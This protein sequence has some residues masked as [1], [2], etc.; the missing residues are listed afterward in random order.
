MPEQ[1]E[2]EDQWESLELYLYQEP[3][4]DGCTCNLLEEWPEYPHS[5]HHETGKKE[6]GALKDVKAY[7]RNPEQFNWNYFLCLW[8]LEERCEYEQDLYGT[9]TTKQSEIKGERRYFRCSYKRILKRLAKGRY[10]L[11]EWYA[12]RWGDFDIPKVYNLQIFRRYVNIIYDLT[13]LKVNQKRDLPQK[14]H[15]LAVF[16]GKCAT[17]AMMSQSVGFCE[18]DSWL[19]CTETDCLMHFNQKVQAWEEERRTFPK[20]W[21]HRPTKNVGGLRY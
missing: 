14:R 3:L 16:K 9:L 18:Q 8:W 2:G 13:R 11:P 5:C 15:M 17:Y 12:N 7:L 10:Y 19:E 21:K 20:T 1:E 6:G 4:D